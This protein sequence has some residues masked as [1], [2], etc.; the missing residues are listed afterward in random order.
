MLALSRRIGERVVIGDPTN[1]LGVIEV[2]A[3]QGDKVKLAFDFPREVEINR[4]EVADRK[5]EDE[6]GSSNADAN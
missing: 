4:S 1:P 5:L 2:V 3:V 6:L